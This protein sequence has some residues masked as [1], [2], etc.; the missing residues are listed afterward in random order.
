MPSTASSLCSSSRVGGVD[1]V[2]QQVGVGQLFERG[3]EGGDQVLRQVGDEA[4]GV[5]DHHLAL[6]REAQAAAGRVEGH[7]ELVRGLDRRCRSGR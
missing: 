5:G 2:Q 1:D 7:E 4:D 6:A 3:A